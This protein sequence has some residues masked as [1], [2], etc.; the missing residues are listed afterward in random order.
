MR[1][2]I[3]S[4]ARP[5]VMAMFLPEYLEQL[6][7]KT[8]VL[9]HI[10]LA[11]VNT[12]L[13]KEL[14]DKSFSLSL[15]GD[16]ELIAFAS[17]I[18]RTRCLAQEVFVSLDL[19]CTQALLDTINWA[20]LTQLH[21]TGQTDFLKLIKLIDRMPKLKLLKV[22]KVKCTAYDFKLIA[23]SLFIKNCKLEKLN[24][25]T[26]EIALICKIYK[27]VLGNFLDAITR[28]IKAK[29]TT[30]EDINLCFRSG[31]NLLALLLNHG[32]RISSKMK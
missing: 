27:K 9:M 7:L 5:L 1:L 15:N 20:N 17:G 22:K 8:E 18:F 19:E 21:I 23:F 16:D 31:G 14:F 10:T 25:K 6:A 13:L 4:Y 28:Y 3:S 24:T 30:L 11:N 32:L 2:D 26:Q 12:S 29:T